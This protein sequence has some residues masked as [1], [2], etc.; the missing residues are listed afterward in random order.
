MEPPVEGGVPIATTPLP[1]QSV[2]DKLALSDAENKHLRDEFNSQRAKM[3]ELYLQK[4]E[5]IRITNQE[6]CQMHQELELMMKQ[7]RDF[8]LLTQ[9]QKSEIESLQMLVQET[10]EESSNASNIEIRRLQV[11]CT[12]LEQQI[13]LLN[14]QSNASPD[15][16]LAP[17]ALV[18]AVTK[19]IARR[20]GTDPNSQDSLED[21]MKK[22]QEDADV[23]RSLVVPLEEEIVALK[24]K[25]REVDAQLQEASQ[26]NESRIKMSKTSDS[27]NLS[28]E[29]L[30]DAG[31][32]MC[33]NYE[34]QLVSEQAK[35]KENLEKAIKLEVSLKRALEE[36]EREISLRRDTLAEWQTIREEV[37]SQTESMV[38]RL[39]SAEK[40]LASE[41]IEMK[42]AHTVILD[43]V[44]RLTVDR[45]T[46]QERLDSLQIENE[47]L[48]GKYSACAAELQSE[49]INLPDNLPDL[50]E[51][52]LKL[53][54][55]LIIAVMG[56]ERAQESEKTMTLLQKH[57]EHLKKHNDSLVGAN[58]KLKNDLDK[59][60]G[61]IEQINVL[62]EQAR[63]LHVE[64]N[65]T[66]EKKKLAEE[67]ITEL[68][69]R[70]SSL[71]QDLDTSEGV[72]QDFVR[73]SQSLQVQLERIR[74]SDVEVRWQ[75]D[76]DVEEC[77]SCRAAFSA[78]KKKQH[79]RHCGR[80][81]CLPCLSH[82]VSSGPR[83]RPAHVCDVCYTLLVRDTAPYF[84]TEVP[85]TP[86]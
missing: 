50:Q 44:T 45:E 62:K 85:H 84:S 81:F 57:A 25:L 60:S 33:A 54:E 73:L 36:L 56:R 46:L 58:N 59:Y 78:S 40:Q 19:R 8:E 37:R 39:A 14:R 13:N 20:L 16:S 52:A 41:K 64:L 76:E 31:C 21:S 72:Q 23:L 38:A 6:K 42:N 80:I 68:R 4:E 26:A 63:K 35:S 18:Q 32:D 10:V 2:E 3:K 55:E 29:N 48:V 7:L 79:C 34:A 70:V 30:A 22:A 53:R 43:D 65:E 24:E 74:G 86:D 77:S 69:T 71:Q 66:N 17:S 82:S 12:E 28:K 67:R 47:R 61:E 27:M 11:K 15:I 51:Y 75:H 83:G 5:E 49:D 1:G 9:S